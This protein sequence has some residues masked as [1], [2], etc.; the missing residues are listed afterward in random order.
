M[1]AT[2]AT[3]NQKRELI[4]V[5]TL[6]LQEILSCGRASAVDVG[7]KAGARVQFG[8]TVKWNVRKVQEYIDSI[9]E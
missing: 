1:R 5:N 8:R 4:L 2:R 6:G 3:R 9:S 7:T